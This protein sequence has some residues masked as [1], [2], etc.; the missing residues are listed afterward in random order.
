MPPARM[1]IPLDDTRGRKCCTS[2]V[3]NTAVVGFIYSVRFGTG[4]EAANAHLPD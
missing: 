3:E 2:F 1:S 4:A